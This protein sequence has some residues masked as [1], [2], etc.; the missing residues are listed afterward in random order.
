MLAARGDQCRVYNR[1]LIARIVKKYLQPPFQ[2]DVRIVKSS[3]GNDHPIV[4]VPPHGAAPICAKAD[5]PN[6]DG[7]PKGIAQGTYYTRKPGP[8]S[9]P[10]LTAEEW[11]P[12][13]RRCAMH[14][15]AAVL[16]AIDAALRGAAHPGA[17]IDALRLWHDQLSYAIQ[18]SDS[19]R[20]NANYLREILHQVNSEVRDLVRTG[21]SMF[22][23][24]TTPDL[25]PSFNADPAS[26]Q[27]DHDFLE[28][29]VLQESDVEMWRVSTDG[30]ATLIREY[31]EDSTD[32]SGMPRA[33]P[34]E[35]F[36][37]NTLA[38]ALA[39][40]L[41]HAR[42][43]A[44]RFD[45]P[46]TVSFLCEWHGLAG[47]TAYDPNA[48]WRNSTGARTDHRVASGTWPV[49]ALAQDWSE[50]VADLGGPVA[51]LFG[52]ETAFTPEWVLGQAAKWREQ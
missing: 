9:A 7:K 16:G 1:D 46:T 51:R 6:T 25:A 26:G 24:Y 17:N 2:C 34:G 12:I 19:Q 15:R 11:A 23:I 52:L 5:G 49:I 33:H 42:G 28:C 39:E 29:Q 48:R 10:I 35:L 18:R 47:R 27:G 43:F 41:R 50:I 14:D 4:A 3:A 40:F 8:E 44:E 20:V 45:T 37:P 31:W 32:F 22:Y 38:Q 36:S 13:I 30:E 21:F